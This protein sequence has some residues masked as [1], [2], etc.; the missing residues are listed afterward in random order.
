MVTRTPLVPRNFKTQTAPRIA[1]CRTLQTV[2]ALIVAGL[3][4]FVLSLVFNIF[5]FFLMTGGGLV[6]CLLWVRSL[7]LDR[8][9]D[10]SDTP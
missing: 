9:R 1:L 8:Q 10:A 3:S 7:G 5:V 6:R 2:Y 4:V